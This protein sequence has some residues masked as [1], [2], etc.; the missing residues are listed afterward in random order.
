MPHGGGSSGG[1]VVVGAADQA[2]CLGFASL[3]AFEFVTLLR[4]SGE[5]QN[6]FEDDCPV[7]M[8]VYCNCWWV[9]L[10]INLV[11]LLTMVAYRASWKFKYIEVATWPGACN[12][13][14]ICPPRATV[15]C[16]TFRIAVTHFIEF[17][18]QKL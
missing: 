18:I 5:V 12:M 10:F 6:E 9:S 15:S 14:G 13:G 2:R 1:W 17:L 11:S 16:A 7:R 3:N 8:L 4:A